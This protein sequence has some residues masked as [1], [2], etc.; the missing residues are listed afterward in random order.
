MQTAEQLQQ[1]EQRIF[2]NIDALFFGSKEAIDK[3][4]DV[5]FTDK[6]APVESWREEL[7][8]HFF[9]PKQNFG[10][11]LPWENTDMLF[12]QRPGELTLWGGINGHGKS[13]VLNQIMLGNIRQGAKVAIAS[14]ELKPVETLARMVTQY[15]GITALDLMPVVVDEFVDRMTGGLYIYRE[16][17]DMLPDRVVALCRYVR[18]ELKADHLV[19]DS[20]MKLG[21]PDGDYAAEKRLVN[22]LQN[23]AKQTGLHIH[24]VAHVRKQK[25]E[26]QDPGKF[27]VMGTS[28]LTNMPDNVWIIRRNKSKEI[29][30][31]KSLADAEVMKQPDAYLTCSKQR[32]GNGWEGTI[33]LWFHES[34]QYTR[35]QGQHR[36]MF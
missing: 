12:L 25:D 22:S 29:E 16:T 27:D 24:L 33:G 1:R 28:H 2:K 5:E 3:Y 26:Q 18:E 6:I 13:L 30:A 7:H 23:I 34:K 36:K 9:S 8:E 21:T 17:G 14:L 20:F 19:L 10:H 11:E 35:K 4:Q 32:H 31:R 15:S